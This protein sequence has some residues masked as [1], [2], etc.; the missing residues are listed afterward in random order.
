MEYPVNERVDLHPVVEKW[1]TF[2]SNSMNVA[3]YGELQ[4]EAIK[5]MDRV[6]YK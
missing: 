3:K 4:A 5:L 6:G 1:G 2:S